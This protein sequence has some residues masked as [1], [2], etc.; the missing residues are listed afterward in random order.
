M[1]Y[2]II[3]LRVI[4]FGMISEFVIYHL[5]KK[6]DEKVYPQVNTI[7]SIAT[8]AELILGFQQ[9]CSMIELYLMLRFS[10]LFKAN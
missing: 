4:F 3:T 2:V 8:Y 9:M 5:D 6:V 7:D 1:T 10:V